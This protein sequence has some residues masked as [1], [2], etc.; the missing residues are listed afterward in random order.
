MIL[1]LGC[2]ALARALVHF[3]QRRFRIVGVDVSPAAAVH[4][5]NVVK[6]MKIEDVVDVVVADAEQLPFKPAVFDKVLAVALVSHLPSRKSILKALREV[7]FCV[8][9]GGLCYLNW[10]LNLYSPFSLL[11]SL[12]NRAGFLGKE[13]RIQLLMFKGSDEVKKLCSQ[14]GLSVASIVRG[15]VSWYLG[16]LVP[17][18]MRSWSEKLLKVVGSSRSWSSKG[19]LP[20]FFFDLVAQK[21]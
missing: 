19:L 6:K 17:R 14:A 2:G 5:R 18:V 7:C 13:Q 11:L 21:C 12:A 16:Y 10:W 3:G 4:A 15:S 8:K 20:S 9:K 1:D